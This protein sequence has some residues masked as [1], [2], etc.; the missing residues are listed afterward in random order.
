VTPGKLD[1]GPWSQLRPADEVRLGD[2][3]TEVEPDLRINSASTGVSFWDGF[4][5]DPVDL[6]EPG[7]DGR[8]SVGS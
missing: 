2:L 7:F 3:R 1:I 5:S 4:I 8:A 6:S